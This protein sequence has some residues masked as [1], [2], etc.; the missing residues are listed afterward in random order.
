MHGLSIYSSYVKSAEI[1]GIALGDAGVVR[2]TES[3][4]LGE[5]H[6]NMPPYIRI[7]VHVRAG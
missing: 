4:G 1:G 2:Q 7:A 5:P 3:S 6:E